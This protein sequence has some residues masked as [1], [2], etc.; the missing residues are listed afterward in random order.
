KYWLM[1]VSSP[2]STSFS[3]S[4]TSSS[5]FMRVRL[6]LSFAALGPLA[7]VADRSYCRVRR[8]AWALAV[9]GQPVLGQDLLHGR[10]APTASRGGQ[11]ALAHLFDRAR[12]V[13]DDGPH[14]AVVDAAAAA[15]DHDVTKADVTKADVTKVDAPKRTLPRRSY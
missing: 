5:P 14:G 6:R 13:F 4:M 1:A 7:G 11:A 8:P 10:G 3:S 15:Q 12:P 2:V 9:L